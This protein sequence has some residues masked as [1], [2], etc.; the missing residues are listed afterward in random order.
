LHLIILVGGGEMY[1]KGAYLSLFLCSFSIAGPQTPLTF[2][3]KFHGPSNECQLTPEHKPKDVPVRKPTKGG[4]LTLGGGGWKTDL[5]DKPF[6]EMV[7][8]NFKAGDDTVPIIL[9]ATLKPEAAAGAYAH[10]QRALGKD[11]DVSP[12]FTT[13][14]EHKDV[15]LQPGGGG[16]G[17]GTKFE[18]EKP[19][20]NGNKSRLIVSEFTAEEKEKVAAKKVS[21]NPEDPRNIAAID[22][23]KTA[24]IITGGMLGALDHLT[25]TEFAKALRRAN[26]RGVQI[27]T[28]SEGTNAAGAWN[29]SLMWPKDIKR[30]EEQKA[31]GMVDVKK[32]PLSKDGLLVTPDFAVTSHVRDPRL[33]NLLGFGATPK[34]VDSEENGKK[35]TI[36]DFEA[37]NPYAFMEPMREMMA[38]GTDIP[39]FGVPERSEMTYE[40]GIAS[41]R[42][43]AP[44]SRFYI[45]DPRYPLTDKCDYYYVTSGEKYDLATGK[46]LAPAPE[47]NQMS[48]VISPFKAGSLH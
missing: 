16:G 6:I 26:E 28:S 17:V 18:E 29:L 38:K 12:I 30:S 35:K 39:A 19:E 44:E 48:A 33:L 1:S 32:D 20:A 23:A 9:S 21:T 34:P 27:L 43:E 15:D 11:V 7:K 14:K 3:N 25:N 45:F 2:P 8:K 22:K 13:E 5:Y 47:V 46:V 41:F 10:W 37:T 31:K 40:N 42:G 36:T 4:K 24:I